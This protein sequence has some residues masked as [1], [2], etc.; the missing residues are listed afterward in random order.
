[1]SDQPPRKLLEKQQ[2]R[3]AEERKR[4]EEK[5]AARRRNLVTLAIVVVVLAGVIALVL[6]DRSGTATRV[7]VAAAE[8]GCSDVEHPQEQEAAHI[9][10]GSEHPPYSSNP[11]TSGPHYASPGDAAFYTTAIEPETVIHNLEHGQIVFWYRPDASQ[12]LLDQLERVVRQEALAS[13]GV[14][15]PQ[16]EEPYNFAIT[17]W[18]A[19]QQCEQVSQ[20]VIDEF[21]REFQGRGPENVGIPRFDG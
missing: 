20:E 17:A 7:G 5:R 19:I 9:E 4:R 2:R 13:I 21:R 14:P 8:A 15:W 16:I 12:E 3:E 10:V 11:P 18:G 6:R 1:M